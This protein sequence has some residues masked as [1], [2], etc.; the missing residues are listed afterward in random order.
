M[1]VNPLAYALLVGRIYVVKVLTSLIIGRVLETRRL[2]PHAVIPTRRL[3]QV[4]SDCF[5]IL[6]PEAL[7]VLW[8]RRPEPLDLGAHIGVLNPREFDRSRDRDVLD[9]V[10]VVWLHRVYRLVRA[11]STQRGIASL[12]S[13]SMLGLWLG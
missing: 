2:C 4:L 7:V 10:R 12:Q 1:H 9:D 5:E 13:E 11:V 3:L 8:I 6:R